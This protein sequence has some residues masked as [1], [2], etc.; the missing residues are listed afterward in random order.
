M[1]CSLVTPWRRRRHLGPAGL[2]APGS[3]APSAILDFES[4]VVSELGT[5]LGEAGNVAVV[6]FIR[7][8]HKAVSA[9]VRPVYALNDLQPVSRT[10]QLGQGSCSQRLAVVEALARSRGVHT[11][12]RGLLVDGKFWYPR[13]QGLGWLVPKS[14]LLAWP[15]FDADGSWLQASEIFGTLEVLA[16]ASKGGF[17]N[18]GGD[19]LYDALASTAIDWDGRTSQ[20][21]ECS[22]C[23]LSATVLADLGYFN[24]RDD[25]FAEY[26]QTLV[27]PIRWFAGPILGRRSPR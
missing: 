2:D 7:A 26:G 8:A 17:A 10:V 6:D 16:S 12:V 23:D 19:T 13:F 18:R 27:A 4:P 1:T 25:L 11:R 3:K 9:Q 22:S 5:R 14:V 15:E 20:P 21:G 24:D